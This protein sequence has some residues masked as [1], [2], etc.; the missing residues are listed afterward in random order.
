MNLFVDHSQ[1]PEKIDKPVEVIELEKSLGIFISH[2][3]SLLKLPSTSEII[4][5][6]IAHQVA[7]I[8]TTFGVLRDEEYQRYKTAGG[9]VMVTVNSFNEAHKILSVGH[10]DIIVYQ[11]ALAGGHKGGF[12][13]AEYDIDA[14]ILTLKKDYPNIPL[15]KS[16][17]I[18]NQQDILL[19][20]WQGFDGVLL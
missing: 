7:V 10:A 8:S 3:C 9:Q 1:Y 16:G 20:L 5:L 12:N 4:D 2:D 6:I 11:N 13:D 14:V 17:G 19:A 18:V 15:I